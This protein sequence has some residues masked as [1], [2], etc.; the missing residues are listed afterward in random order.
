MGFP[1]NMGFLKFPRIKIRDPVPLQ[2]HN[3]G[4]L[5]PIYFAAQIH[6]FRMA[7]WEEHTNLI[8]PSFYHPS[9]LECVELM[10]NIGRS[11]WE[12]RPS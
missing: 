2:P 1:I 6:G 11:N 12:V 9:S 3:A 10:R 7:L 4:I 8:H 5:Y